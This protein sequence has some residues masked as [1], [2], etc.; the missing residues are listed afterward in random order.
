MNQQASSSADTVPLQDA[1]KKLQAMLEDV[2]L[3][4]A[5]L[6]VCAFSSL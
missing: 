4:N 5:E 1:N 6:E 2:L 3:H